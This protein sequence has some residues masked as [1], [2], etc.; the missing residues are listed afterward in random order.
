MKYSI[1]ISS[2][3]E[4]TKVLGEKIR[5]ALND[6]ECIYFGDESIELS[7]EDIVFV[8]F[9]TDKG[10]CSKKLGQFLN[11]L[12]NKKIFLFGTAGFGGS[13]QYFDQILDRVKQNIEDSNTVI[14][15]YMCQGKMPEGVKVRYEK[16]LSQNPSDNNAKE[17]LINFDKALNH[18]NE[19]DLLQLEGIVLKSLN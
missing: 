9:W 2:N 14:G 13:Q 15:T 7:D 19:D 12:E 10:T 4:N 11:R 18:P 17:L 1:V 16:I 3:T 8:G 5:K 6:S